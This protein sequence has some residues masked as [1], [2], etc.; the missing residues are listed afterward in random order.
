MVD[1]GPVGCLWPSGDSEAT[2]ADDAM[3]GTVTGR[4]APG[5]PALIGY[6]RACLRVAGAGVG[7]IRRKNLS[8]TTKT[9]RAR[10]KGKVSFSK[11][12]VT[13]WVSRRCVLSA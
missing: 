3:A 11:S 8:H 1:A 9:Q 13:C 6:R 10:R 7:G 5:L 12:P 4:L 2:A